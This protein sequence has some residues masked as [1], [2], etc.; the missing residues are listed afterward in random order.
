MVIESFDPITWFHEVDNIFGPLQGK[1]WRAR[2]QL[3]MAKVFKTEIMLLGEADGEIAAFA[4]GNLDAEVKLGYIDLL[5]V[6]RRFQGRGYG[7]EMLRA[8]LQHFKQLGAT[9]AH[10]DCLVTNTVGNSLYAAEGFHEMQ[11]SIR[12]MIQIP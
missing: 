9:H 12:W 3:R 11:R 10:L 2:W 6:D 4:S 7:R 1:D 5:A 8:M